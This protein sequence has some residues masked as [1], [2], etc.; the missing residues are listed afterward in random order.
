MKIAFFEIEKWEEEYIKDKLKKHKLLFFNNELTN[1][2]INKIKDC[3]TV[4]IFIYSKINKEILDNLPNLKLIC[5]M[6]TGF[7]HIDLNECKKRNIIV[8][9][10]PYYGENTVAEHTFALILALSRKLIDSV[11]RVKQNNF[12]IKGLRGFDVKGKTLGIIGPG[13][14]GQHVIRMAKGFEMKIIAYAKIKDSELARKFSF[15]YVS[16]ENLLKNSDIISLHCPLNKET[17]HMISMKN[18]KL[19]KKGA[20]L[21][22]TARGGI[23]E[24][25]A[26]VYALDHGILAGAGLDV[27]EGECYIK[28]EKQ[29]LHKKFIK[30]CDWKLFLENHLLLQEKN[31]IVTPH[32]AFNSKEALLR[33]IDTTI[34]NIN[35]FINKKRINVVKI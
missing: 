33:I 26:L 19:I 28:E 12:N 25:K 6:S 8:S 20:Y 32:N 24:T 10:V 4:C 21:I 1:R 14:I 2:N 5:T 3:D 29:L 30:E 11:E 7:D 17:E 27:L 15:R 9:N 22:N 13:H 18:I 16:L 23:V 31:V 34:E 35:N